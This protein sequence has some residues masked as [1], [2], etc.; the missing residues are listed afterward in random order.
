[1]STKKARYD[2]GKQMYREFEIILTVLMGL[3]RRILSCVI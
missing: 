3:P 1:M 2:R